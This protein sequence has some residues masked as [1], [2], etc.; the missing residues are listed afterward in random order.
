VVRYFEYA[1]RAPQFAHD[2]AQAG[3]LLAE[4]GY[5]NGFDAG[6]VSSDMV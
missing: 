1:W 3:R 6:S 2:P 5:P 4:A